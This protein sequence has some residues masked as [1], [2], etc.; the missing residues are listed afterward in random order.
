MDFV[1]LKRYEKEGLE[2]LKNKPRTGRSS[3]LSK[4]DI[5]CIKTTLKESNN[6]SWTTKQIEDLIVKKSGIKYHY[7][8]VYRRISVNGVSDKRYQEKY[9][10]I[11]HPKKRNRLSKKDYRTDICR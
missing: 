10:L 6:Q 5:C 1:W 3:E 7:T 8:Q 11:Q 2:A 9:M 4:E